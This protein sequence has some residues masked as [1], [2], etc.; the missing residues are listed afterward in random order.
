MHT[1][2]TVDIKS[3]DFQLSQGTRQ[4]KWMLLEEDLCT[5]Y[6]YFH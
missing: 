2:Q 5:F 6:F 4:V 3:T 1:Q